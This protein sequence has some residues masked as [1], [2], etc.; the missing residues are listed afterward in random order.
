MNSKEERENEILE[1]M[2]EYERDMYESA[3]SGGNCLPLLL[4]LITSPI[5]M[6]ITL[7]VITEL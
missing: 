2:S 7:F 5:V 3:K 6:I 4:L 1:N